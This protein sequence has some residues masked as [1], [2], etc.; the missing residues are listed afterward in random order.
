[1]FAVRPDTLLVYD[2]VKKIAEFLRWHQHA[3]E[4]LVDLDDTKEGTPVHTHEPTHTKGV[5]NANPSTSTPRKDDCAEDAGPDIRYHADHVAADLSVLRQTINDGNKCLGAFNH[6][7]AKVGNVLEQ[8]YPHPFLR[9]LRFACDRAEDLVTHIRVLLDSSISA[10]QVNTSTCVSIPARAAHVDTEVNAS[11]ARAVS[12]IFVKRSFI[13]SKPGQLGMVMATSYAFESGGDVYKTRVGKVFAGSQAD[14]AG[15]T[16]GMWIYSINAWLAHDQDVKE[17]M[18]QLEISVRPLTLTFLVA[19]APR[20]ETSPAMSKSLN[21]F[22]KDLET[23]VVK[24]VSTRVGAAVFQEAQQTLDAAKWYRRVLV[25]TR[26]CITVN[27]LDT[28]VKEADDIRIFDRRLPKDAGSSISRECL[29]LTTIHNN[30][31]A[32]K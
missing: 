4:T 2:E 26:T 30:T 1:M 27:N 12:K 24:A 17:V 23:L 21:S 11:G 31:K 10:R 6:D 29:T 25:G 13:L 15:I 28:L 9:R 7:N 18:K 19:E 3:T 32:I 8:E 22:V 14:Q 16:P 20:T 5:L